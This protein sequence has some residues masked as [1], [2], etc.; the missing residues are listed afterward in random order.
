VCNGEDVADEDL[1]DLD[2]VEPP[3]CDDGDATAFVIVPASVVVAVI[4]PEASVLGIGGGEAPVSAPA[5][6]A[7]GLV[8]LF[9]GPTRRF[10]F[11]WSKEMISARGV[12]AEAKGGFCSNTK[13]QMAVSVRILCAVL[14]HGHQ[15]NNMTDKRTILS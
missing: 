11:F 13:R 8:V 9:A 1:V 6:F 5:G 12:V 4:A 7:R 2:G 14:H 3:R 10:S 15:D